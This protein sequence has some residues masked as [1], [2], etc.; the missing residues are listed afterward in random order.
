MET[1]SKPANADCS[2]L[3]QRGQ[4]ALQAIRY[5]EQVARCQAEAAQLQA[6]MELAKGGDTFHLQTWLDRHATISSSDSPLTETLAESETLTSD[7]ESTVEAW[8]STTNMQLRVDSPHVRSQPRPPFSWDAMVAGALERSRLKPD[9]SSLS[10]SA[11]PSNR[12]PAAPLLAPTSKTETKQ[13]QP[14]RNGSPKANV[15]LEETLAAALRTS[16][17]KPASNIRRRWWKAAHVWTS[18]AIHAAL[19]F[20]LSV[21]VVTAIQKP[22]LLAIVSGQ[23]ESETVL[24]ETPLD[25][26]DPLQNETSEDPRMPTMDGLSELAIPIAAPSVAVEAGVSENNTGALT[27]SVEAASNSMLQGTSANKMSGADF[28]GVKATGNTFVYV[29]DNSPSMRRDGAFE[30]ARKEMIRSLM[31][32]KPK[33]RFYISFFGKEIDSMP[34]PEG[35]IERFPIHATPE[36]LARTIDWLNRVVVQKEGLP[37]NE[38]LERAI[39]MQPDGI[40]LLFDGDTKVDVAKFL[41]KANRVDDVIHGRVPRVPIQVV[42]FFEEEFQRAMKQIADENLGTY[43]FIPRPQKPNKGTR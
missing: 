5:R 21:Y 30:A 24:M 34:S 27:T 26:S 41:R 31:S 42:H 35:D 2:T 4:L 14:N 20:V 8:V 39:Q 16:E 33:Q 28:F 32:M 23:Q 38:A 40:F 29:V 13:E 22:Q 37:P 7:P 15:I 10:P 18:L 6:A 11:T 9:P 25:V 19:V 12:K 3:L 43:R 1:D 36:N 17:P